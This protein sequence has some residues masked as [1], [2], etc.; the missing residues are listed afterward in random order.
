MV[1]VWEIAFNVTLQHVAFVA[2]NPRKFPQ[3]FRKNVN[4]KLRSFSLLAGA[5]RFDKALCDSRIDNI[6]N[7]C[8][9]VLPI[10]NMGRVYIP[11]LWF[12]DCKP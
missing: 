5:I 6:V 8:V 7:K 4:A 10:T 2:V 12:R 1:T 9:L 11:R 3:Q